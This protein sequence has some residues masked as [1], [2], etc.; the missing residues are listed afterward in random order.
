M[1]SNNVYNVYKRNGIFHNRGKNNQTKSN[2]DIESKVEDMKSKTNDNFVDIYDNKE[3]KTKKAESIILSYDG[4]FS[5]I[6]VRP[7]RYVRR[8]FQSNNK[9]ETLSMTFEAN[10]SSDEI[11]N[12][13]LDKNNFEHA[14][15]DF[16][17]MGNDFKDGETNIVDNEVVAQN[18]SDVAINKIIMPR[19]EQCESSGSM[20]GECEPSCVLEGDNLDVVMMDSTDTGIKNEDKTELER[21]MEI[22]EAFERDEEARIIIRDSNEMLKE[23]SKVMIEASN[24][25]KRTL[26]GHYYE[27]KKKRIKHEQKLVTKTKNEEDVCF[28]C[29]DGGDLVLCDCRYTQMHNI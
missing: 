22:Y 12:K 23:E 5:N 16:K 20:K 8:H 28:I 21:E 24:E 1:A 26:E 7:K 15:V 14:I 3:L 6:N 9:K 17:L 11:A 19:T 25:K 10:Q 13:T 2:L 4:D 29:F 18:I 27:H